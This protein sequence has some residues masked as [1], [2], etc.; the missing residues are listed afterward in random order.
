MLNIRCAFCQTPY[1]LSHVTMLDALQEVDAQNLTHYDAHCPRCRRATRIPRQRLEMAMPNWR[2]E[3]KEFEAEM[4]EHP[5]QEA[6]LPTPEGATVAETEPK[7]EPKAANAAQK[8]AAKPKSE[9]PAP[10]AKTPAAKSTA[11]KPA[12][13]KKTTAKK[14]K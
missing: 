12:A 9:K 7:P 4:K 13:T 6:P 1:T 8:P 3:L 14:S 10:K 11:K 2:N 5:Q